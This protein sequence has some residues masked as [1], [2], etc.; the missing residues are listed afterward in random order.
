LHRVRSSAQKVFEEKTADQAK[1]KIA[2]GNPKI[3]LKKNAT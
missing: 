2:G 1:K 3:I